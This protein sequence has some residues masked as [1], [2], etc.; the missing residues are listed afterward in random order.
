MISF[1]DNRNAKTISLIGHKFPIIVEKNFNIHRGQR[2]KQH[3][4]DSQ[5]YS[6]RP[7]NHEYL[8]NYRKVK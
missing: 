6:T 4:R 1:V 8:I 7:V 5:R 2:D 3:K